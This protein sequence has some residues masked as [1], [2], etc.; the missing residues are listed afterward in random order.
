MK[1][2]PIKIIQIG[3]S[4]VRVTYNVVPRAFDSKKRNDALHPGNYIFKNYL[5]KIL[6]IANIVS[7]PKDSRSIDVYF[8][9]KFY[10]YVFGNQLAAEFA[11]PLGQDPTI[12]NE[13][14]L[15]WV[16]CELSKNIET[17]SS[18]PIALTTQGPLTVYLA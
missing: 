17:G 5:G 8:K 2:L 18:Y 13:S 16:T 14:P 15:G 10:G 4:S 11:F 3:P 1:F 9:H 7:T 6:E 12:N